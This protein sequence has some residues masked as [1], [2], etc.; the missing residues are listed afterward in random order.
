MD[1]LLGL[2][3]EQVLERLPVSDDVRAAL[4]DG[5]GPHAP[6]L[7]L[8]DAYENADWALVQTLS[9]DAALPTMY[10]DAVSWANDRLSTVST[11]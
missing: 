6:V 11:P 4:I 3:M 10:A 8:A 7:R 1:T 9:A 5:T 2:P